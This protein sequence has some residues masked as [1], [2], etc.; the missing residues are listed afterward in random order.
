M[1]GRI[2]YSCLPKDISNCS[3]I[4]LEFTHHTEDNTPNPLSGYR[5]NTWISAFLKAVKRFLSFW[6]LLTSI[7]T[8]VNYQILKNL[9]ASDSSFTTSSSF[10]FYATHL[11]QCCLM[12]Y[13]FSDQ[14]SGKHRTIYNHTQQYEHFN[15]VACMYNY[16]SG[17]GH[18]TVP[19]SAD[20]SQSKIT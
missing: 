20:Y 6:L 3:V 17:S 10:N 1:G 2:L 14:L 5:P 11:L 19:P 13:H 4:H 15:L 9:L 8:Y 18:N 7:F 16:S 12:I